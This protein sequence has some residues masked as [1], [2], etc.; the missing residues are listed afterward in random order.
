[1]KNKQPLRA[2]FG[3]HR[4]ATSWIN[5][6]SQKICEGIN[7]R[8]NNVYNPSMFNKDLKSYVK[9]NNTEFLSYTNANFNYVKNLDDFIGFHVIRDPRDIVVSGYYSH[10]YSVKW[11]N[12]I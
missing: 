11:D 10:L 3:H 9:K 7:L 6:I 2:F 4:C 5:L 1:M 12:D 8:F